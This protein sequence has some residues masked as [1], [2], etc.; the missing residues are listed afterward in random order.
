[1]I[2]DGHCHVSDIWY[3]PVETLLFEMDRARVERAVLVQL[4]GQFDNAYQQ[5]CLTRY[6]GRFASAVAVDP[7]SAGAVEELH[8]LIGAGAT[9]VRLRPGARSPGDDPFAIWRAAEARGIAVSCVGPAA[10]FLAPGFGDIPA[11]V[12][13]LVIV[14]EH[15]GGLARPDV[16]DTEAARRG[17][18]AL[19]EHPRVFLKVPGIGQLSL[20]LPNLAAGRSPLADPSP[21]LL[22]E[23]VKA[24][25]P[26][27]L[28]W[29]SDF[30]PVAAREGYMNALCWAEDALG[31][32]D[33][34][35]RE[36]IFGD[37]ARDIFF[38]GC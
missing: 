10:S 6:P 19:A 8:R 20:R 35:S 21:R 12:P 23:I 18:L 22:H 34:K 31:G 37:N 17:I 3:E 32:L 26:R 7:L 28:M 30:P 4:L 9:A 16:T 1:M 15:L 27:R 2:V 13:R 14:L 11:S 36:S 29:G 33:A 5:D 24:Y 38:R 25:G